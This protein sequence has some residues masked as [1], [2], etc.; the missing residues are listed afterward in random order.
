MAN[1]K[2]PQ[3]VE[4]EDKLLGPFTFKQFIFMLIAAGA[5]LMSWFMY[6]ISPFMAIIPLPFVLIFG[7]LAVMRREDQPIE[8]YLLSFINYLI[9]PR[10]RVWDSEGYYDH[11]VITA[12]KTKAKP[13]LKSDIGQV[14]GQLEHLAQVV[15]TRGWA[16]KRPDLIQP[17]SGASA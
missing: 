7:G 8:R 5:A 6:Q 2:V 4:A 3:D 9:R 16:V 13:D 1:Y 15:D 10:Q 14:K 17:G 12:P 11:L